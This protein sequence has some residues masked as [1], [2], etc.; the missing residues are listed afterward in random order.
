MKN[1]YFGDVN[2]YRK[3]GLLRL[4]AGHGEMPIGV[5]WMLT[6]NDNR[7]DGNKTEYLDD[8]RRNKWRKYDQDLY[9]F[10]YCKVHSHETEL[11]SRSVTN[12]TPDYL[13]SGDFYSA[14][15]SDSEQDRKQYFKCMWTQFKASKIDLI[16]FDPDD[17][18]ANNKIARSPLKKGQ[19]NS[20]K[21][22][23]RDEVQDSLR[24]GFSVIFYQHF[25]RTNRHELVSSIGVELAGMTSANQSYSF[26]TPHVVFFLVPHV[27]HSERIKEAVKRV[28]TSTWAM[29]NSCMTSSKNDKRQILVDVHNVNIEAKT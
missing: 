28:D 27:D 15:L 12:L 6:P 20:A 21:K 10:L 25:D 19:R 9:D 26:W 7:P 13:P 1:Q 5:C 17:G 22:L 3:Y 16:F 2:D 11:N 8:E 23:F 24:K 4:L 29:P 14:I 18:L